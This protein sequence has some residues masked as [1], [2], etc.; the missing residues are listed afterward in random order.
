M[1]PTS[2]A[3]E[4]SE[5]MRELFP[6][7]EQRVYLDTAAA[8]LCWKGHGAAVARFYED[9]KSR[10]YDARPEWWAMIAK[11]RGRLA[12][13]LGVAPQ[14]ITFVSNTTEGLNLAASSIGF[15]GGDRIVCAQDEFPSVI[16]IWKPAERQGAEL[17]RVAVAHEDERQVRLMDAVSAGARVLV[18][19]HTHSG[20]GTT[21]DLDTLGRH[22]RAN[23]TLF[24]VDGIQ[25][26]GAVH[27]QLSEVDIYASS[28]FKWMLSGFGFG[29]L[30]TSPRA[31]DAMAPA[32]QGYANMDDAKQLQYAHVNTPALY[33]LDATLDLLEGIGWN[34]IFGRVR[35][36]GGQ[37]IAEADRLG[38]PLVT[39]RDQRAGIFVFRALDGEAARLQLAARN[40]SVSAR[41][42][43]VRVSPHFYNSTQDIEQC[44]AALA[45][46][47]AA[48]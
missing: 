22:C 24:M 44:A 15:R 14:D 28:F 2:A 37:L 32:W 30:V 9:V 16:R 41:G 17:V 20:T 45:E 27:T 1:A 19:S 12:Q 25:A 43:G 23:G 11:V 7:L 3:I 5:Q 48:S 39:P 36:L 8:G 26:L 38:L 18:V 31:R 13:W 4:R 10:G 40:I 42:E 33:G 35:E 47:L 6:H 21:L 34:S 29:V 46:V